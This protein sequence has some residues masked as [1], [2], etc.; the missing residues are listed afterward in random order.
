ML[1]GNQ[2]A[3]VVEL[4]TVGLASSWPTATSVPFSS[5]TSSRSN[6]PAVNVVQLVASAEEKICPPS[7]TAKKVSFA[8]TIECKSSNT[9]ALLCAQ[10]SPS[11]E[12]KMI[13]N[14]PAA[15]NF[16]F[17]QATPCNASGVPLCH[18]CQ[19]VPLVEES[20]TP[21][22]PVATKRPLRNA[23]RCSVFPCGVGL[24]QRQ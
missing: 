21:L 5:V 17:P 19:F 12:V 16:P 23:T 13:P 18:S 7:P 9:F 6:G 11:T 14:S 3:P 8:K 24:R 1:R 15:T 4:N 2:V 22:S 20:T 10:S